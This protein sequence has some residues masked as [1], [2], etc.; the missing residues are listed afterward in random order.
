MAAAFAVGEAAGLLLPAVAAP[1]ILLAVAVAATLLFLLRKRFPGGERAVFALALTFA[2]LGFIRAWAASIPGPN[3][4]SRFATGLF[5]DLSGTVDADPQHTAAGWNLVLDADRIGLGDGR[6]ILA[7][8][9]VAVWI[10][11]DPR[12]DRLEMGDRVGVHGRLDRP[13]PQRNP[14]GFDA[15][16]FL[17]ARSVTATLTSHR[18]AD[19][20]VFDPGAQTPLR[21]LAH[22][23]RESFLTIMNRILGDRQAALVDGIVLGARS[24]MSPQLED[25]F[26]RTGTIHVLATAGLHVGFVMAVL[27]VLWRAILGRPRRAAVATILC[28][29]VYALAAGGRPAISRA[30][31]TAIIYLAALLVDREPDGMTALAAAALWFLGRS[32]ELILD[33]GFQLSF[34]TVAVIICTLGALKAG[35]TEQDRRTLGLSRW[36]NMRRRLVGLVLLSVAAQVGSAPLTAHYFY[37]FSPVSVLANLLVVPAVF[38]VLIFAMALWPLAMAAPSAAAAVAHWTLA[39]IVAWIVWIVRDLAVIPGASI[40]VPSPGWLLIAASY[41]VIF[42]AAGILGGQRKQVP[43]QVSNAGRQVEHAG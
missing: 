8:G 24:R 5:A 4:V 30:V 17:A 32:P 1:A 41:S 27:M 37:I 40:N 25:D 19:L 18:S 35:G 16:Q 29:I 6:S 15:A 23:T 9:R 26:S 21:W 13:Q 2:T 28:L 36:E 38:L 31:V 10:P 11:S 7:T 22:R 3:D 39:P 34:A 20:R 33:V 42:W 43:W 14:G 12:S